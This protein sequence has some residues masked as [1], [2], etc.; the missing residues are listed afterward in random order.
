MQ[1]ESWIN[2]AESIAWARKSRRNTPSSRFESALWEDGFNESLLQSHQSAWRRLETLIVA[3]GDDRRHH[4]ILVI[5]VADSPAQLH[6]CL[7]SLVELCRVYGCC[8]DRRR[9][10]NTSGCRTSSTASP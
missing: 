4:F 9:S 6:R 5:P 2:Q 7:A 8:T 10:A 1:H 3:R